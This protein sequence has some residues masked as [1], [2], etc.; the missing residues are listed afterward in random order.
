MTAK[1]G[2][3]ARTTALKA[4][5]EKDSRDKRHRVLAAIEALETIGASI[6]VAAVAK[7]ARVSAWL[8]YAEG[9]RE[10]VEAARCRQADRG[11]AAASGTPVPNTHRATPAGLRTEL[12]VARDEIK[13]L[14]VEQDRLRKRLRLH[15]GAEI[16]GPDRAQLI[17]RVADLEA[18]NRQLVTERDAREDETDIARRRIGELEDELTAV[19][20]SLRRVIRA[21]NRGH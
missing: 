21:E 20:E 7:T 2:P 1:T 3:T 11:L 8:V 6:T 17:T 16:E 5:R 9:V 19:R 12:A 18:V 13:R 14:R 10:H 4:A 15:L